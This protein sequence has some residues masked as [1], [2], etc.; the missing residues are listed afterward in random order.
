MAEPSM[1]D[2]ASRDATAFPREDD[3]ATRYPSRPTSPA[4]GSRRQTGA[5][6]PPGARPAWH[7]ERQPV[8]PRGAGPPRANGAERSSES[9]RRTGIIPARRV[10][11]RRL[12]GASRIERRTR[13]LLSRAHLLGARAPVMRWTLTSTGD[14]CSRPITDRRRTLP[15][16]CRRP[17]AGLR[18]SVARGWPAVSGHRGRSVIPATTGQCGHRFGARVVALSRTC[19]ATSASSEANRAVR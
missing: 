10:L 3:V 7:R 17:N 1:T 19:E 2:R 12:D 4:R 5:E 9:P 6:R 16:R 18:R 11:Y 8:P 15:H 14:G 13:C